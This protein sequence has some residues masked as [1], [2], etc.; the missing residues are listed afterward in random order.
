MALLA[1]S[2]AVIICADVLS[3]DARARS[4]EADEYVKDSLVQKRD[5]LARDLSAM[6]AAHKEE[7][8]REQ[9]SAAAE[10][11]KEALAKAQ[12]DIDKLIEDERL[13]KIQEG[14]DMGATALSFIPGCQLAAGGMAAGSLYI[15]MR[16]GDDVVVALGE[17]ALYFNK[18]GRLAKAPRGT[19]T[20]LNATHKSKKVF[21]A[22]ARTSRN[23]KSFCQ[24]A[25]K[26]HLMGQQARIHKNSLKHV[27]PTHVY[28]IKGPDG[29]TIKIGESALGTRVRDG[30]SRRAEK[31]VRALNRTEGPGHTSEIRRWFPDKASARAYETR[32]IERFR[33]RFG[34]DELPGNVMNR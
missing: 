2:L 16:R 7:V 34:Q 6:H 1:L 4:S 3:A 29:K 23:V 25:G 21:D 20:V 19:G 27:G 26:Q 15:S 30:A 33:R 12:V 11:F 31:Q 24:S 9:W 14:L 10:K 8:L 28:R 18:F 32:V 5:V 13:Q 17:T 22:T